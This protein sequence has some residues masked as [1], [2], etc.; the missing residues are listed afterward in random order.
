M[1]SD[2]IQQI[3]D[4]KGL[5]VAQLE[6]IIGASNGVLRHCIR[7]NSDISSKWVSAILDN[8]PD[9]NS[10]WLLTGKGDMVHDDSGHI[11]IAE[12]PPSPYNAELQKSFN[13]KTDNSLDNQY[14]P[15]YNLEAT[16][17][18][19]PLFKESGNFHTDEYLSIPRL[20]KCDGAIFI[21]G[22]SMY[23]LL[24]SGDIV[25]YKKITDFVNEVFYGEMYIV[26]VDLAGEEYTS[27][28]FVHKSDKGERHIKLVSQNQHH[29]DK[30]IPLKMVR[31]MA[32][33]KASVRINSM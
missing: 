7:N 18:I 15:L 9:I 20:P 11:R 2:R 12:E 14:I 29:Q 25:A 3:I 24:K 19:V 8:Y 6:K 30:D 28:K 13:L 32:L 26:A 16:A 4:L 23:P 10:S 31:A 1:I 5:R 21:T 17:G 33:V 22:D 27:V